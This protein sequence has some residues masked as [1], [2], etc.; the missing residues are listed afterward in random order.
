[1]ASNYHS[2]FRPAEILLIDGKDHLIRKRENLEDLLETTVEI[3][4]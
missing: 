2:R 1:M 3:S 4:I